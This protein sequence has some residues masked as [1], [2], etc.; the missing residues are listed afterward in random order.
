MLKRELQVFSTGD[1]ISRDHR[2]QFFCYI[3]RD[4]SCSNFIEAFENIL[5]FCKFLP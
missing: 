5:I 1:N 3:L 2:Q 4:N